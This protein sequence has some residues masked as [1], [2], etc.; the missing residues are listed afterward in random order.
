M[1]LELYDTTLRDGAQMEGM[2]LSVEDKLKIARKLDELGVH[3]IE[4]GWP[5][6]NPKDAEFFVR[7]QAVN[8][9]NARLAAFGSTRKAGGDAETDANLRALLDARTPVVTLVGKTSDVQVRDV[10]GTTPEENLSMIADSVR[11]MAAHGR[12]VFF[13]AE[14]FFDGFA[15][16]RAYA[17]S[18]LRA[19]ASAGAGCLVLCDTNGGMTTQQLVEAIRAV[20]AEVDAPLGIHTHNDADLA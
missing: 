14:H 9:R 1:K 10:L 19:A 4:G 20:A 2:S 8:F 17:L 12:T 6:S 7:A 13:D 11:M 18:C 15:S 16:N 5:G 3:Y